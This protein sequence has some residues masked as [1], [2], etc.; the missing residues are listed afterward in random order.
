MSIPGGWK[1]RCPG[2]L[3][4]VTPSLPTR[5]PQAACHQFQQHCDA[6]GIPLPPITFA[7]SYTT[8][9]PRQAGLSGSSALVLATLRC[10]IEAHS[11]EDGISAFDL[12]S[13]ALAVET[14]LGIAAGLQDRVVQTFGGCV[15]MD[16]SE[17]SSSGQGVYLAIDPGGDASLSGHRG[18]LAG[19]R[20]NDRSADRRHNARQHCVLHGDQAI[21]KS[22]T[23]HP[24]TLP[25]R[26]CR[27][28]SSSSTTIPPGRPADRSMHSSRSAG[29]QETVQSGAG[30]L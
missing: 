1:Q 7:L 17:L 3:P 23:F 21:V 26:A 30:A 11:V 22:L 18:Q 8:N 20:G 2:E 10:L 12:P 5:E 27:R 15:Y 28:C 14:S 29:S 25:Q 16:F 9:I 4:H 6:A 13:L 19:I 24:P